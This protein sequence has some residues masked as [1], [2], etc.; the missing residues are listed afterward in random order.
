MHTT[1]ELI[2]ASNHDGLDND[3]L[4]EQIRD[5]DFGDD[6]ADLHD[7]D[8]PDD[9]DGC[10]GQLYCDGGDHDDYNGDDYAH[11]YGDDYD[12]CVHSD[13]G[14]H[15]DDDCELGYDDVSDS[16]FDYGGDE[17]DDGNAPHEDFL[18]SDDFHNID[19]HHY[20]EFRGR[21][22][23]HYDVFHVLSHLFLE[24]QRR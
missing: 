24:N 23:Y 22:D 12:E 7:V 16:H 5:V 3:V 2:I 6:D 9:D 13:D 21:D 11:Q 4:G 1:Q 18:G 19:D 14:H 15:D 8:G 20:D 10:N 17:D